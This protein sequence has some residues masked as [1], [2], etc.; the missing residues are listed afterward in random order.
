MLS[1]DCSFHTSLSVL[2][3]YLLNTHS[4]VPKGAYLLSVKQRLLLFLN[5]QNAPL[6]V[7]KVSLLVLVNAGDLA[8]RYAKDSSCHSLRSFASSRRI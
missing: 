5:P 1:V 7:P 2:H 4:L 3:Q 8:A 6:L